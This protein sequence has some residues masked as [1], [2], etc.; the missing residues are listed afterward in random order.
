MSYAT[1]RHPLNPDRSH[2]SPLEEFSQESSLEEFSQEGSLE[3]F[4]R[5]GLRGKVGAPVAS[6]KHCYWRLL[7]TRP[8]RNDW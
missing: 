8:S 6:D 7:Q 2:R 4:S 5:I 3:E 1:V